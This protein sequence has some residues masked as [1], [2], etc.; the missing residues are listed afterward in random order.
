MMQDQAVKYGPYFSHW[1]HAILVHTH[2]AVEVAITGHVTPAEMKELYLI[3]GL[4]LM[5]KENEKTILPLLQ[6]KPMSQG[7]QVYICKDK[8]CGLPVN[9]MAEAVRQVRQFF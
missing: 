7:L 3:P 6:D 2:S 4:V 8:T 1:A 9:T 5:K